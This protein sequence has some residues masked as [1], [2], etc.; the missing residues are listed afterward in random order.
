[1]EKDLHKTLTIEAPAK[2]NLFLQVGP[3][4]EDGYHQVRTV[5]QTIELFDLLSFEITDSTD[6]PLLRSDSG[7]R[8]GNQ[9][10]VYRAV[11]VFHE[12]KGVTVDGL[13]IT[14][15]K[16]IPIAAGLGGGSSDAAATL[17]AL[18]RLF[19]SPYSREEL[20]ILATELGSDVPFFLYGGT[21]MAEGRG[22]VIT[23]LPPA[24]P[25]HV[26]LANPGKGLSTAAVYNQF[27]KMNKGVFAEADFQRFIR[28]LRKGDAGK[29]RAHL[30]NDLQESAIFL[31]KEIGRLASLMKKESERLGIEGK[32][33]GILMSG[34]GPTL[35]LLLDKEDQGQEMV[36][37]LRNRVPLI[38][39]TRFRR[40]GPKIIGG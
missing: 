36:A 17:I 2:I 18:N 16:N 34:S 22:E 6:P 11:S 25:F 7:E 5:L 1:M 40:Q 14:L 37:A 8:L 10:L 23:P 15:S 20:A 38:K 35:F 19:G 4:R 9:N 30:H 3:L 31:E 26:L 13:R 21:V 12:R 29:I 24:P 32:G 27:D 39:L 28:L 33:S